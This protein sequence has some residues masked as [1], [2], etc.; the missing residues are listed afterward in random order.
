[1]K[2][3]PKR[4]VEINRLRPAASAEA[5]VAWAVNLLKSEEMRGENWTNPDVGDAAVHIK[6]RRVERSYWDGNA[7]FY[8]LRHVCSV[9]F[10]SESG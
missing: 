5:T 10:R 1:M 7:G 3:I 9:L 4:L 6:K 8:M 2:C